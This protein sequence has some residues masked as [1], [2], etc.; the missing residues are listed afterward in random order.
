[1]RHGLNLF[2]HLL[3]NTLKCGSKYQSHIYSLFNIIY[4]LLKICNY[5]VKLTRN[6]QDSII[7][8]YWVTSTPNLDLSSVKASNAIPLTFGL[9]V[10][11]FWTDLFDRNILTDASW[12]FGYSMYTNSRDENNGASTLQLILM[13]LCKWRFH[14]CYWRVTHPMSCSLIS[15]GNQQ[16]KTH[17]CITSSKW[18][19]IWF[20][21]IEASA[22]PWEDRNYTNV[23][24]Y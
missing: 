12:C 6:F 17:P 7:E 20:D 1:M 15:R 24:E 22:S 8:A 11:Q 21:A 3:S 10:N 19:I 2:F 5:K 14:W 9:Y 18:C 13:P 23:H 4:M 16:T